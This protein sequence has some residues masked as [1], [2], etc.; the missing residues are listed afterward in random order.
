MS[1]DLL[2]MF[3][4]ESNNIEK[5][6]S[7]SR[8]SVLLRYTGEDVGN[9]EFDKKSIESIDELNSIKYVEDFI[10]AAKKASQENPNLKN[11]N[12]SFN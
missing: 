4:E 11:L 1:Y 9:I 2:K 3:I 10:E 5:N 12:I 6:V 8:N 7:F